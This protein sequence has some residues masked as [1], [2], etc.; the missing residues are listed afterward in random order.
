[1]SNPERKAQPLVLGQKGLY[2][3]LSIRSALELESS[4]VPTLRRPIALDTVNKHDPVRGGEGQ[5]IQTISTLT[6]QPP[7][8]DTHT[9]EILTQQITA[10]NESPLPA[11]D[12]WRDERLVSWRKQVLHI[13]HYMS[14]S[15]INVTQE[16]YDV[17]RQGNGQKTKYNYTLNGKDAGWL[18]ALSQ[19]VVGA[20]RARVGA[21]SSYALT[22]ESQTYLKISAFVGEF[23]K[24]RLAEVSHDGDRPTVELEEALLLDDIQG[25]FYPRITV[26]TEYRMAQSQT[27][28]YMHQSTL[29]VA[30][31][32]LGIE[33][34]PGPFLATIPESE[35]KEILT[36]L[37]KALDEKVFGNP[38]VYTQSLELVQ[39]YEEGI[40]QLYPNDLSITGVVNRLH[41]HFDHKEPSLDVESTTRD[42]AQEDPTEVTYSYP[43]NNPLTP[44]NTAYLMLGLFQKQK[45]ADTLV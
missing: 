11:A 44:R 23:G 18:N 3:L 28:L 45:E 7:Q 25:K 30:P 2:Q 4:L 34:H 22:D 43:W 10:P 41:I 21:K 14:A 13:P 15:Q 37:A 9:L 5:P 42:F 35:Q 32:L 31:T 24:A 38:D 27:H 33:Y 12:Y 17:R 16:G 40:E 36:D 1:M 26:L 29:H 6:M 20:V 19:R 39:N 8:E